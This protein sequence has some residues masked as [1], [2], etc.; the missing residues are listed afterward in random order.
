MSLENTTALKSQLQFIKVIGESNRLSG[1]RLDVLSLIK[2]IPQAIWGMIKTGENP[3]T[4]VKD[5]LFYAFKNPRE[6]LINSGQ[7]FV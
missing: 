1:K 2:D 6:T 4:C 5:A 7:F 3:L